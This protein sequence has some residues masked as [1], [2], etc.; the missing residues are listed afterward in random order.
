MMFV[1]E[2]YYEACFVRPVV[3]VA[4]RLYYSLQLDDFD[5]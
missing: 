4:H 3:I 2:L 5:N 1:Q